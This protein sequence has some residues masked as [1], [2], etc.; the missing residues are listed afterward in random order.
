[1]NQ[2]SFPWRQPTSLRELATALHIGYQKA[3]R[4]KMDGLE[5]QADGSYDLARAKEFLRL[6]S[7]RSPT[8]GTASADAQSLKIRKLRADAER[9][10]IQVEEARTRLVDKEDVL[11]EWR[12]KVILVKNCFRGLG[13]ELAARLAGKGPQEVQAVI[14]LRVYE[15]LRHFAHKHFMPEIPFTRPNGRRRAHG[16]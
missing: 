16:N 12:Q 4:L 2:N 5:I 13:R 11:R 6:R 3:R 9:V 8:W 7:L 1:M 10:E 14:D 15:I